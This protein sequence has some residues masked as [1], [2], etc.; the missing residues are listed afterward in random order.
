MRICPK[1]GHRDN[2]NWR[3][4]RF[5]F[6][7]DY[8]RFTEGMRQPEL[9]PI[10]EQLKDKENFDPVVEGPYIFYRRGTSG[11]YLYRVAKEDFK[12]PRERKHHK[13]NL[14]EKQQKLLVKSEA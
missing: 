10:C 9:K 13:A 14:D 4:S 7:A 12:V 11:L 5:D 8:M 2:A 6:N 1:C 3:H